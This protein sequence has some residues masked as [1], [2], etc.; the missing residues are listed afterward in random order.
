ML[1]SVGRSGEIKIPGGAQKSA[2]DDF[3]GMSF[4]YSRKGFLLWNRTGEKHKS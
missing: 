2:A 3:V 1:A 4:F